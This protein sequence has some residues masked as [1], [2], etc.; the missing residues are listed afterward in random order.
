MILCQANGSWNT[1]VPQCELVTGC[2]DP[3]QVANATRRV[4]PFTVGGRAIYTCDIG[5][6]A[7][8]ERQLTCMAS[9]QWSAPLPRC[10]LVQCPQLSVPADGRV[11]VS[12]FGIDGTAAFSCNTGYELAGQALLTCMR[13]GQ[14]SDTTPSCSPVECPDPPSINNG[15]L[16]DGA[17]SNIFNSVAR[18]V[19][20]GGFVL[21]GE[22]E[23]RCTAEQEWSSPPPVC[24]PVT[25]PPLG[26]VTNARPLAPLV[27]FGTIINVECLPS[28][29][30][31][32][33]DVIRCDA[34]GSWSAP[35]PTCDSLT[36]DD[37][38]DV[39]NG[40]KTGALFSVGSRV[41]YD[42][43]PG[44]SL[45]GEADLLCQ[46]DGSWTAAAPACDP[47]FCGDPGTVANARLQGSVFTFQSQVEFV[48]NEGFRRRGNGLRT[49]EVD[50]FW[51]GSLPECLASSC[52]DPGTPDQ[53]V[54][55][56]D[57]FSV[58]QSVSYTCAQGFTLSGV[59]TLQCL[60]SGEWSAEVP[61]CQPTGCPSLG[62]LE[63][64]NIEL[65]SVDG[66]NGPGAAL[67]FTCDDG[68]QLRA[69][70]AD[71]S[72]C[73]ASGNWTNPLPMCV[74][75]LCPV[76][77]Q[78][79]NG[80]IA[81][82][83]R[84]PGFSVTV[85]CDEGFS[86]S[87]AEEVLCQPDATWSR[88]LPTCERI[89]CPLPAGGDGLIVVA[90]RPLQEP[91]LP[92]NSQIRL[93]CVSG[94]SAVGGSSSV[95]CGNNSE[96]QPDVLQCT[97]RGCDP[98][99]TSDGVQVS[100]NFTLSSRVTFSCPGGAQPVGATSAVCLESGQWSEPSPTCPVS[101]PSPTVP[102]SGYI[103]DGAPASLDAGTTITYQCER[104]HRL[105]GTATLTCMDSGAW[106]GPTPTCAEA[107]IF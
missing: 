80:Q 47:V 17:V 62:T 73:L 70:D 11:L 67:S 2:D 37:P 6:Q 58:G 68:Y 94:Y 90:D 3:G 96:W 92:Y 88:E 69:G 8:G 40:I 1:S 99:A 74:L 75:L 107:G 49:C 82:Y 93:A 20:A 64:G 66:S 52:Q 95:V 4:D 24:N 97:S 44:Y 102:S 83:D 34:S 21:E 45:S 101:C 27:T 56:G 46:A 42:C 84:S 60:P 22:A 89:S 59:A 76:L 15:Q 25:C 14:W 77:G 18:Y 79:A 23:L 13:S 28:Y 65:F 9:G 32:H 98:P 63:N 38:G 51:S 87:A 35:L 30:P 105:L 53:A 71:A 103:V 12:S 26:S 48:C 55:Q 36:C 106:N 29:R 57:D 81:P 33:S 100:G 16:A 41:V 91:A 7:E 104:T 43:N 50:G 10:V 72:L 5:F 85:I 78:V 61:T 86:L 19:C 39:A 31:S 54:R